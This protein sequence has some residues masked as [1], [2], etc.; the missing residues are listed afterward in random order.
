MPGS[1]GCTCAARRERGWK[2]SE[3]YFASVEKFLRTQIPADEIS[4][5]LDNIGIPNSGINMSLSDGS[6]ISPADGEIL[7][8]LNENHHPTAEYMK[9]LRAGACPSSFPTCRS[10]SSRPTL[11]RRC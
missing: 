7:I 8:A 5:I 9:K 3:L 4:V 2:Q 11:R 1:F 6:Q 10:G